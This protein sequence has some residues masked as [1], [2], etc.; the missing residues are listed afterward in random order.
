MADIE[1]EDRGIY[2]A[3]WKDYAQFLEHEVQTLH[4]LCD[5]ETVKAGFRGALRKAEMKGI[6][7]RDV[8][9]RWREEPKTMKKEEVLR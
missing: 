3:N 5:T 9:E 8:E 1:I 7:F 4:S 2:F 6:P